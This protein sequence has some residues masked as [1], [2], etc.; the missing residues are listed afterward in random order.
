[1]DIITGILIMGFHSLR[2][3]RGAKGSWIGTTGI[4]GGIMCGRIRFLII[5]STRIR[6]IVGGTWVEAMEAVQSSAGV[7][8]SV[9]FGGD[10]A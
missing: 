8:M 4:T 10:V 1:M 3:G 2:G 5:R 6:I 9:L 7:R